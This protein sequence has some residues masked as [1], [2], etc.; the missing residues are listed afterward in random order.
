MTVSSQSLVH[1]GTGLAILLPPSEGK[2]PGGHSPKWTAGSGLFGRQLGRQR[3][4]LV[5]RLT[6][7]GGGDS[8]IL[9]VSG[10]HL[11]RARDAN[12][13]LVGAPTLPAWQRY[14]G[15][16]WDHLDPATLS[17]PARQ[18]A[19]ESVIIFSGLL[20]LVGFDDGIPDY[21]LKMGSSLSEIGKV[22]T[23][24]RS[25]LSTVLN[26]WLDNRIVIDLLPQEHR[27][28]W[29]P[30]SNKKPESKSRHIVVNFVNESGRTV[31]HDAKAAKGLLVR[32][33]LESKAQPIQALTSWQHPQFSLELT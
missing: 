1:P 5:D 14:T 3:R 15:V 22:S 23:W 16:V 6:E 32:H 21:K 8:K 20:G 25:Q 24:W 7:L 27:A 33:L 28:A 4:L 12:T 19:Q 10:A 18:R 31:G 11:E 29:Q 17:L 26:S 30:I 2:A 13:H 9:G